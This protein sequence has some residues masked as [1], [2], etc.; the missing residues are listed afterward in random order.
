MPSHPKSSSSYP[1]I[2]LLLIA[3]ALR[4]LLEGRPEL[5]PKV[6]SDLSR[7]RQGLFGESDGGI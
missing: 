5:Q 1:S 4:C 6:L 2:L 3:Q 7:E